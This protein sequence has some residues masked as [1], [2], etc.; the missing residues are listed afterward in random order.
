[1]RVSKFSAWN[2]PDFL[3]N[4]IGIWRLNIKQNLFLG[5]MFFEGFDPKGAQ[6][7]SKMR[8]FKFCKKPMGGAFLFCRILQQHKNSKWTQITFLGKIPHWCFWTKS[9]RFWKTWIAFFRLFAWSYNSIK[10]ENWVRHISTCFFYFRGKSDKAPKLDQE[11][12]I[13]NLFMI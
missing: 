8:C 9:V 10:A 12:E 1:M 2:F 13:N 11:L 5:K 6:S 3:L 4:I 7:G